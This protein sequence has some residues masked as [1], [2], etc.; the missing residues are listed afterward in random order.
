[1]IKSH[2][3][4]VVFPAPTFGVCAGCAGFAGTTSS[5]SSMPTAFIVYASE[6]E[7]LAG[8]VYDATLCS[9]VMGIRTDAACEE[10]EGKTGCEVSEEEW[11]SSS[12]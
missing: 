11:S 3:L 1:M 5:K 6:W 9:K 8:N 7:V 12:D 4:S 10:E 2:I